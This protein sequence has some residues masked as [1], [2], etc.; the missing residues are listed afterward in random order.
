[1][2]RP[3]L[4]LTGCF[5]CFSSGLLSA[6]TWSCFELFTY[7]LREIRQEIMQNFGFLSKNHGWHEHLRRCSHASGGSLTAANL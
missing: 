3:I 2:A 4:A 1:M 6:V 7:V 5:A